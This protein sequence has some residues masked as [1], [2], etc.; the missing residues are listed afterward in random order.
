M[1]PLV[2]GTTQAL[3][4]LEVVVDVV[5]VSPW[6]EA[7]FD[8]CH[9][10]A[11]ERH[12]HLDGTSRA[13]HVLGLPTAGARVSTCSE[14]ASGARCSRTHAEALR[15]RTDCRATDW[16]ACECRLKSRRSSQNKWTTPADGNSEIVQNM[17]KHA[18][19]KISIEANCAASSRRVNEA[20]P[21]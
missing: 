21:T 1:G 3:A 11:A 9:E 2:V 17:P 10:L 16:R 4:H 19:R 13:E 12:Q 8:R 7:S 14:T 6:S 20:V 5:T 18:Q 15:G